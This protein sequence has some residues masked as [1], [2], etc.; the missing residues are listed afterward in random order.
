M[1]IEDLLQRKFIEYSGFQFQKLFYEIMRNK[2][3]DDFE[4]PEH[5]GSCGDFKCDGFLKS[6]GFYFACYS[7]EN[8]YDDTKADAIIS[9]LNNDLNGLQKRIDD[10]TW[11]IPFNGFIFVVNMKYVNTVPAPVFPDAQNLEIS[12]KAK[13]GDH[14]QI[15][16]WTQYDLKRIF[17]GLDSAIQ[18]FI[19]N[20]VYFHEEDIDFSGGTVA[21]ILEHFSSLDPKKVP[22]HN[23]M[24]FKRKM[25]FNNLSEER[26]CDLECASYSVSSLEIYLEELGDN[27]TQTLQTLLVELYEKAKIEFPNDSNLQFDY[28]KENIYPMDHISSKQN[29][30]EINCT[31]LIIMSKFFENCS[32]FQSEM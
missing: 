20:K 5:Y 12:L 9:K 22:I 15:K 18:N 27:S 13:Y 24:D 16:I 7:P 23:I 32:I 10:G 6:T 28:I 25:I 2:N 30:K 11:K 29:I 21:L 1:T 19:I 8:P 31:K 4:M 26:K 14:F 17:L 3:G